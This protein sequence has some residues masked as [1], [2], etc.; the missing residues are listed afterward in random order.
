MAFMLVPLIVF[1]ELGIVVAW[2]FGKKKIETGDKEQTE[3]DT[4]FK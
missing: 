1:Y 4:E 3:T 2:I